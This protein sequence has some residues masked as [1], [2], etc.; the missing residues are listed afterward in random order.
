MVAIAGMRAVEGA[1]WEQAVQGGVVSATAVM[2]VAVMEGPM[3]VQEWARECHQEDT[4]KE[5]GAEAEV[6][7]AGLEGALAVAVA[8]VAV[9][10]GVVGT[11]GVVA[12]AMAEVVVVVA[13]AHSMLKTLITQT[14]L[15]I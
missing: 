3:E 6:D 9:M 1:M 7:T 13:A 8:V 12:R 14:A 11:V 5:E 10:V 4:A 15:S 2:V